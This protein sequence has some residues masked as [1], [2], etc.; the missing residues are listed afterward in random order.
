MESQA[1]LTFEI[2]DVVLQEV[3]S[4]QIS[5][6]SELQYS[7]ILDTIIESL[8]GGF[9]PYENRKGTTLPYI[10]VQAWECYE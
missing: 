7:P 5:Q 10:T 1:L 8:F 6:T 4:Q 2:L 9:L 3:V